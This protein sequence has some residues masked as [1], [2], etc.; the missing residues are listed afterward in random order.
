MVNGIDNCVGHNFR[1][2]L[3]ILSG[4]NALLTF[5]LLKRAAVSSSLNTGIFVMS[6]KS[7]RL[8]FL[9]LEIRKT[10]LNLTFNII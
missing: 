4:P 9:N 1:I 5:N 3:E 2:V 8:S 6:G 7:E 10:L